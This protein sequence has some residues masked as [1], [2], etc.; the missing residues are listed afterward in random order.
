MGLGEA[1][2]AEALDLA[3]DPFGEL[4]RITPFEHAPGQPLAMR[5]QPAM[6]FPGGHRAAQV[7]GFA[8]GVLARD[9]RQLHHLFLEQRYAEGAPEH[10]DQF[11]GGVFDGF[12]PVPP[13]QVGMHHVALDRPGADDGDLDHQVVELLRLQARQHRHLRPRLDLEHADGVGAADHLVGRLV[14]LRQRGEGPAL[15]AIVRQ[16]VEAAP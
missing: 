2:A 12:F 13:A 11:V 3:E 9:D 1:V 8:G 4:L 10:R 7:V 5:F 15:A 16:Q 14:L 6:A